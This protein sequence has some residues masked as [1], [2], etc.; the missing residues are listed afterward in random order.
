MD[1]AA[2]RKA[3]A[4]VVASALMILACEHNTG[5]QGRPL[6]STEAL[7]AAPATATPKPP[8]LL[9]RAKFE[10][11]I[12]HKIEIGQF[13]FTPGQV[14]PVHTHAAPALGYVSKGSIVYQLE[15]QPAQTLNAG[16]AFFEPVGPQIIHFDNASQSE[17]A[18]FTDFNFEQKGEPFI[19]FPTPPVNLK[20]DRRTLPT[21]EWPSGVQASAI[22]I[23]AQTLEPGASAQRSEKALPVVGYV[24]DGSIVLRL[25]SGERSVQAGQSFDVPAAL[26]DVALTNQSTSAQAKVVLFE[27]AI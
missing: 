8:V 25:P 2:L 18:I 14:A 22:D 15:G 16:D 12:I 20:V 4:F 23:Y 11:R 5:T 21:V 27:P 7:A 17:E 10:P 26:A 19:V 24:A 13:H 1:S 9:L 6:R 3:N